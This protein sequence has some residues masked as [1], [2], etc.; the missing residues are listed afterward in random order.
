MRSSGTSQ[1]TKVEAI[2]ALQKYRAAAHTIRKLQVGRFACWEDGMR[3]WCAYYDEQSGEP[4]IPRLNEAGIAAYR[5][6]RDLLVESIALNPYY[7]DAYVLLANAFA[8]IDG[9]VAKQL[10]YYTLALDLDPNDDEILN[11]RMGLYLN[12]GNLPSAGEDLLRLEQLESRYAESMREHYERAREE[13]NE[14][15]P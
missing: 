13:A 10:E 11:A 15:E 9:D 1:I 6:A 2:T 12:Q 5:G 14:S 8:E 3:T 4:A 7:P